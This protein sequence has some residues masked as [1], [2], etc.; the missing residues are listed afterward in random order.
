MQSPDTADPEYYGRA[1]TTGQR[2]GF[3]NNDRTRSFTKIIKKYYLKTPAIK[4]R[5]YFFYNL[6]IFEPRVGYEQNPLG[7]VV[8]DERQFENCIRT[9]IALSAHTIVKIRHSNLP[10][11]KSTGPEIIRR[12][13]LSGKKKAEARFRCK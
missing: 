3:F 4:N 12:A 9:D 13:C 11:S 10:C 5:L 6:G 1:R 2:H 7:Y 8:H